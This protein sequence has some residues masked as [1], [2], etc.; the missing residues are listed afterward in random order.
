MLRPLGFA[1]ALLAAPLQGQIRGAALASFDAVDAGMLKKYWPQSSILDSS[2]MLLADGHTLKPGGALFILGPIDWMGPD[3]AR[4]QVAMYPRDFQWGAQYFARVE[5]KAN[6][7][8]AA[9]VAIG[10]Q[11]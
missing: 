6:G 1:L 9:D 2:E 8:Q 11:N 10:W 4:L 5:R 7:W 3:A